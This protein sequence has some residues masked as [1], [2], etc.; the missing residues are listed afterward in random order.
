M[1]D[2]FVAFEQVATDQIG[3]REI[4]MTGNRDQRR[5]SRRQAICST[6]RVLPQP[7]GPF[8]ITGRCAAWAASKQ[9]DLLVDAGRVIGLLG[10]AIFFDGWF[11]HRR[12]FRFQVSSWLSSFEFRVPGSELFVC[13]AI[14]E[15]RGTELETRNS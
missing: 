4:F 1:P 15:H 13:S 9:I 11:R 3:R 10:D 7:V 5:R 8:N 12:S 2:C 14:L 6:K